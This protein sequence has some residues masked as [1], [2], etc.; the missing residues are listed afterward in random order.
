[1]AEEDGYRAG[2]EEE[3]GA[4]EEEAVLG[5][6][7]VEEGWGLGVEGSEEAGD[8][9]GGV[10]ASED[11]GI[12][13]LPGEETDEEGYGDGEPGP[14]D[15]RDGVGFDEAGEAGGN[16]GD[17]LAEAA[18]GEEAEKEAGGGED[19]EEGA[20]EE[21]ETVLGGPVEL[22]GDGPGGEDED[23]GELDGEH[24]YEGVEE[25]ALGAPRDGSEHGFRFSTGAEGIGSPDQSLLPSGFAPAFGRAVRRL[26][27]RAR[28]PSLKRLG[29]SR[30]NGLA[31][32]FGFA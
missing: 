16:L 30:S 5:P 18:E 8:A 21:D 26:W 22:G 13:G 32:C 23:P 3:H 11:A 6:A 17:G 25:E 7:G 12:A 2:H 4:G 14:V 1:M 27:R 9:A 10:V 24:G 20:E 19:G 15:G 31:Y 29:V 28:E